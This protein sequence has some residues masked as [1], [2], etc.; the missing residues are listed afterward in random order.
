MNTNIYVIL[1]ILLAVITNNINNYYD[2]KTSL[3]HTVH[4]C[5]TNNNMIW[6]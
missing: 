1:Y 4:N 5:S 6:Y 3:Y 2:N